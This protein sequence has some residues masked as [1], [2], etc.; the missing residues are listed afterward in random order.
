MTFKFAKLMQQVI[1][2]VAKAHGL[3]LDAPSAALRLEMPNYQPLVVEKIGPKLV[4]VCHYR[5]ENGDLV[6]DPEVVFLQ[7]VAGWAAVEI[8]QPPMMLMGIECGGYQEVCELDDTGTSIM[9]YYPRRLDEVTSFCAMWARNIRDQRWAER[10]QKVERAPRA[11]P[12]GDWELTNIATG[13]IEQEAIMPVAEALALNN[14]LI[15]RQ[16]PQRWQP[17]AQ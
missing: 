9:R 6:Q 15:D 7:T 16:A 5:E 14:A 1:E 13:A 17:R 3:D 2:K 8:T 10:G 4:S 12:P 11:E